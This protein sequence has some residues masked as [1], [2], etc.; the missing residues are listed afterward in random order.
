M[1][2]LSFDLKNPRYTF[3]D[4]TF[5][6]QLVTFENV[7][8]LDAATCI[9]QR[10]ASAFTLKATGFAYAGGQEREPGTLVLQAQRHSDHT[11][12]AISA[13]SL[14]TIRLVKLLI[15]DVPNAVVT[16]L[17]ETPVKAVPREGLILSYPEGWRNLYTPLVICREEDGG[18][19]YFRSL[20][21]EVR[22]KK[23]V[24][25]RHGDTL[26]VELIFEERA[27]R[28]GTAIRVPIWEVGK[29]AD[30]HVLLERHQEYIRD[31]Y[32]LRSWDERPDVP[33]W[34]RKITLIA[35]IHCQH[36][37]GHI[38][39]DY[40]S[41]LNKIHWLA[42]YMDPE[43]ILVYLPGWEGRYYWQYGDYRPDP[44]MGGAE[45]FA[46][47][48]RAARA[49]GVRVMPMFGM[50]VANRGLANFEQWG[51]PA[52]ATSP[53]GMTGGSTVDWDGSRH[54]DH[55]WGAFLNI[56]APVW[57]NHLVDQISQLLDRYQFDGVFLDISAAWLNDPQFDMYEGARHAVERIREGRP[58]LLVAGEGWYDAMSAVLPLHQSGHTEGVMHR[59]DDTFPNFFDTYNRGFGHLC[60]GDPGRNSTG[61]HELG[62]NPCWREPFRKGSIPTVTLVDDTIQTAPDKVLEIIED[63]KCYAAEFWE[64]A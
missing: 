31:A 17:R 46:Q 60:L 63:A 49:I 50:N 25:V 54:Y 33:A 61:V 40:A 59:H 53:T 10:T 6:V 52:I 45:G 38:F 18:H 21:T 32:N 30:P 43:Q 2:E 64:K 12:F 55:G 3:N 5:S 39:N 58:E 15:H 19:Y 47:L 41:V 56:G 34:A 22:G 4:L 26:D 37:T 14:R 42:E 16:N 20:D 57:Q 48:V 8:T 9:E 36:F 23:F 11:A 44:R 28:F 27:T 35:S 51:R 29:T 7:Y 1:H 24:F 13:T 62:N